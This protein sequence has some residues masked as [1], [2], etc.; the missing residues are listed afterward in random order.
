MMSLNGKSAPKANPTPKYMVHALCT[1]Q[2]KR[3]LD[4]NLKK[5]YWK[6]PNGNYCKNAN[7]LIISP[8]NTGWTNPFPMESPLPRPIP[9]QRIWFVHCACSRKREFWMGIK[10]NKFGNVLMAITARTPMC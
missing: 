4:G 8:S 9:H 10:K 3:I 2:E 1:F 5:Q 6:C 7:A